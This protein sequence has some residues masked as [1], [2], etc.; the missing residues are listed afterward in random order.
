MAGTSGVGP[1]PGLEGRTVA[2]TRS[3][4]RAGSMLAAL[5][6]TGAQ[7]VLVP[8]IDFELPNDTG[9]LDDTLRRLAAGG[10][11]WLVVTSITTVR[12]LAQ[13]CAVLELEMADLV[14]QPT[15]VAAVGDT[16]RKAL[17]AEGITV[18]LVPG[19]E[20]SGQ[21]LLQAWPS[22]AR[23]ATV[24][25]PQAD[26]ADP[27]LGEGLRQAGAGVVGVTAY[28]TVSYP[29]DPH[30]RLDQRLS[31]VNGAEGRTSPPIERGAQAAGTTGPG[32]A[33]A[34]PVW[35]PAEFAARLQTGGV[36]ALVLTSPSAARRI[37]A[38]CGILD[39]RVKVVAIGRPTA[40]EAERCGQQTAATAPEPSGQGIATALKQAL[41]QDWFPAGR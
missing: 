14:P 19:G 8:V 11:D 31:M 16:T 22:E 36:D 38:E 15:R 21:G 3:P 35:T 20:R 25:L 6:A 26:I 29:A 23:G 12:A 28:R 4:D 1:L 30:K 40:R 5:T 17:E 7:M 37:T 9:P 32:D 24:L 13:R 27:A 41:G 10:F 33:G 39:H 2:L 34:V 18:D